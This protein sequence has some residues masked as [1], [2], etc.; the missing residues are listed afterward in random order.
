MNQNWK[1]GILD[2]AIIRGSSN[3]SLNKIK[4]DDGSYP[5]YGAKGFVQNVS[6]Y[7]Q[8]CEYLGIIK[9]GAGIGR[10]SK[11]PGKSSILATMQYLIPKQGY[12]IQFINYF[13]NYIDF[14]KYRTGSTIPHIYYKD[15]KYETFPLIDLY[16]QK[17]IVAKLDKY[18]EAIDKARANVEKNLNNAKELFQSKLNE[19]FSQKGDGW[20]EKKL[21]EIGKVSMCKRIYKNQTSDIGEIPFYKIGTFGKE[22]NA[23]I[24]KTLYNGYKSNYSFPKK[25][26]ILISASGTIGRRVKY[27]GMPAYFQDSNIVWIDNNEKLL[28][29]DFLDYFYAICDWQP[30]RGATISRLYN[31]DLRKITI[32]FPS[33]EVQKDLVLI[34]NEMNQQAQKLETLYKQKVDALDELK[35]SVLQKAFE[36]E[37]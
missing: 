24:S 36:G 3:I 2:D 22:P 23:F 31:D 12:D 37:L 17:R 7:Q 20:V 28:S 35:K 18:F 11:H 15:Y 27:D 25:G 26:D 6:F 34:F 8:A 13:L 33:L 5:V 14:E 29:N 16:E 32:A 1:Y 30:S 19:V 21:G 10:V 4:D 9:D